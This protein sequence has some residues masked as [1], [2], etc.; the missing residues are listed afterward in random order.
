[1]FEDVARRERPSVR[2]SILIRTKDEAAAIGSTLTAVF[3]QSVYPH[4]VIV[5]D[6]G[7]KDETLAIAGRF[8]VKI[9]RI[10][11]EEWSYS[12]AL[13]RAAAAATGEALVCLSA[14]CT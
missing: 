8:P 12:R 13:N 4:E 1:M 9:M 11:P 3:R 5:I 6:S 2:P 7:S 14:H 10:D